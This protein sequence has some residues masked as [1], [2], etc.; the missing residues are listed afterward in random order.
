MLV[1][2]LT[3]AMPLAIIGGLLYA[4]FFVKAEAVIQKVEP[5][6]VERRDNFFSVALPSGKVVWA[7]GTGG[8]IVRSGDGGS[9]WQ[10]QETHVH[11]N[12]QGIAAWDDQHAAAVGNN[13]VI[14]HTADGGNT[15]AKAAVPKTDNPNKLLRV[16][17]FDGVAWAVGEFGALLRSDDK[18][19]NWTRVLPEKDRA[20]N[21]VYFLGQKGWIVGEFGSVM[22]TADGGSTWTDVEVENKVSLMGV[23]FRDPMN[24][25][26]VGLAGTVITTSDG[27]ATWADV[28]PLTREHLLDV[29]LD[30]GRWV[31]VGDKGVMVSAG[32]EARDWKFTRISEG[33]VSWRTQIAK[34]GNRY[35]VAGANLGILDGGKLTIVGR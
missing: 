14:L 33:D 35:Y 24:G 17:I 25:I 1:S 9:S 13:G 3:S 28:P 4:G 16:K 21:A 22:R 2:L 30:D 32:V 18:G 5:R 20:W 11:E 23:V 19:A 26:A 29:I 12:L 34:S 8:K 7:A 6:A 31:A 10:R 15:W 27:G